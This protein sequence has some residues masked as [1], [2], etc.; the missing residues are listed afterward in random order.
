MWFLTLL[1]RNL[2]KII[3]LAIKL[4]KSNSHI[5]TKIFLKVNKNKMINFR[6]DFKKIIAISS[7][8]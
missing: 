1:H 8:I 6:M 3:N 2:K 7:N 5:K 4:F